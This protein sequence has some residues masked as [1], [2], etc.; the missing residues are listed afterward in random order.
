MWFMRVMFSPKDFELTRLRIQWLKSAMSLHNSRFNSQW[1]HRHNNGR[2]LAQPLAPPRDGYALIVLMM[3]VTILLITLATALPNVYTA[4]LREREEELIFR[5]NEYA[6]AIMFF[7]RQ[8][9]RYPASVEELTK[10][11]N[12]YRF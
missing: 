8:F 9:N 11:T 5:G 3:M 4:G 12:G 1:R 6:R 10:Q 7:H 2:V